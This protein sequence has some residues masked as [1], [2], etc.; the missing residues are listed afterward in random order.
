MATTDDPQRHHFLTSFQYPH[1]NSGD[2]VTSL[3]N[4][5][6][7]DC[8]QYK[9]QHNKKIERYPFREGTEVSRAWL[10]PV[11]RLPSG[12]HMHGALVTI[13][14]PF[15]SGPCFPNYVY[16]WAHRLSRVK[17][18]VILS[19]S[20][21]QSCLNHGLRCGRIHCVRKK[22]IIKLHVLLKRALYFRYWRLDETAATVVLSSR[23]GGRL[24]SFTQA[25]TNEVRLGKGG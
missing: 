2:S 19:R 23:G 10:C 7:K 9:K 12:L 4:T 15:R 6:A 25:A 17:L 24:Q 8:R 14:A 5:I 1:L 16:Q 21:D 3:Y 22:N 20:I 13:W 18:A 11:D